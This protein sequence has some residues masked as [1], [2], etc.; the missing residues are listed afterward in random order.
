MVEYV[1]YKEDLIGQQ[2]ML[3]KLPQCL[4]YF[5]YVPTKIGVIGTIVDCYF[6]VT[7]KTLRQVCVKWPDGTFACG[8]APQWC[9]AE[10]IIRIG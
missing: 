4:H 10:Y 7:R 6:D 5:G 3:V 9:S 1:G 8:N 2:C